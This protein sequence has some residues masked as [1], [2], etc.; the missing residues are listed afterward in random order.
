MCVC[1]GCRVC[2]AFS[3]F[4]SKAM[5][6]LGR[7]LD[8]PWGGSAELN[9]QRLS[10]EN[11]LEWQFHPGH[12]QSYTRS[13]QEFN[14]T[15]VPF[16]PGR[17]KLSIKKK[18]RNEMPFSNFPLNNKDIFHRA[19][20]HSHV[21]ASHML[22]HF[23][24]GKCHFYSLVHSCFPEVSSPMCVKNFQLQKSPPQNSSLL[25]SLP[26]PK[27]SVTD[28]FLTKYSNGSQI[29]V[30]LFFPSK[31]FAVCPIPWD[32]AAGLYSSSLALSGSLASLKP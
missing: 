28:C 16:E 20:Y 25:L 9:T 15:E 2:P 6:H 29:G 32:K 11:T 14:T 23:H 8:L 21:T 27:A 30:P 1:Q 12:V 3:S 31:E 17:V 24:L 13:K 4:W 22:Q 10:R 7:S 26:N 18:N 19:E 5:A